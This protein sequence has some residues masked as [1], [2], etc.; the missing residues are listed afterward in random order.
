M[1]TNVLKCSVPDCRKVA[2]HRVAAPWSDGVS[3]GSRIYG[4]A[5][6]DHA[7]AV[8]ASAQQRL[9]RSTLSPGESIGDVVASR[10]EDVPVILLQ[11]R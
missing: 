5:C 1:T 11:A 9:L 8:I 4:Y 2:T 6:P 7:Q 3:S 10:R